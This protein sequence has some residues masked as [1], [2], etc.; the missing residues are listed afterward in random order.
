SATSPERTAKPSMEETSK[1]GDVVTA[2]TL[3]AST[4][5]ATMSRSTSSLCITGS[6]AL[7]RE[8]ASSTP[9]GDDGG[10]TAV[11]SGRFIV[12]PAGN[13]ALSWENRRHYIQRAIT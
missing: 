13:P 9:R 11:V 4:R 6:A 1:G 8:R 12:L 3:R 10:E 2:E 7:M 5:P